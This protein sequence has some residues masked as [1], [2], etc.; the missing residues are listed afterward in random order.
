MNVCSV[1]VVPKEHMEEKKSLSKK[2]VTKNADQSIGAAAQRK[3]DHKLPGKILNGDLIAREAHYHTSCRKNYTR[4]DDR[5]ERCDKDE[6][7]VEELNAN[8]NA[9]SA[10]QNAFNYISN[11]IKENLINGY[12]V[13]RMIMLKERYLQ[14]MYENSPSV[15]NPLYKTSKLKSTL[16]K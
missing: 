2:C 5:N 12:T 8:Q 4:A 6:R 3:Q 1:K 15:Y 9:F 10:H 11:Y 7:V 14:F 16:M 13:E